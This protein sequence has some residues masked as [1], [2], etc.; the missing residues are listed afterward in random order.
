[1]SHVMWSAC[2]CVFAGHT[3]KLCKN[4]PIEMPFEGL[5]RVVPRNHY[6]HG[7]DWRNPF[8]AMRGDSMAMWP[9]AKLLW[10]L[11]HLQ[12]RVGC[13]FIFIL[14]S[15]SSFDDPVESTEFHATWLF[16]LGNKVQIC[17]SSA[18]ITWS[19]LALLTGFC[20]YR[21]VSSNY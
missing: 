4:E 13:D 12:P 8:T 19:T 6:L 10:T 14:Y 1:M 15:I 3:G 11:V 18:Q 9:F 20:L 2:L 17:P 7:Q 21:Y 16:H 5:T